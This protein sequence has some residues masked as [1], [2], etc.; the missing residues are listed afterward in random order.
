MSNVI[1]LARFW[2]WLTV[3]FAVILFVRPSIL[4]DLK[5]L[6]VEN[7]AFGLS[8]GLLSFILGLASVNLYST[9]QWHWYVV[10][11]IFG[12]SALLKGI[13]VIAWPEISRNASFEVRIW[14]TRISLIVVGALAIWML[15]ASY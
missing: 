3:I 11:T 8:Y 10:V 5:R 6:V 13:I 12:W 4:V 7:R 15:V 9:W 1:L 14:S 2:G